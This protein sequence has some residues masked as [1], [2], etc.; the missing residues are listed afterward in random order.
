MLGVQCDSVLKSYASFIVIRKYWLYSCIV[1][2]I[3][4][5]YLCYT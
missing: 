3:I 5:S 2:Y 1:H 4:V